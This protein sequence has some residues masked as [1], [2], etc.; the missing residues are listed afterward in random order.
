MNFWEKTKF[1]WWSINRLAIQ[2]SEFFQ[3]VFKQETLIYQPILTPT[4]APSITYQC[5]LPIFPPSTWF[6]M[7]FTW[8]FIKKRFKRWTWMCMKNF[9][10]LSTS[11]R[12]RLWCNPLDR[13]IL[14]LKIIKK[15]GLLVS[16]F[17]DYHPRLLGN[18]LWRMHDHG[19]VGEWARHMYVTLSLVMISL[20][21]W[22]KRRVNMCKWVHV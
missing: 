19:G 13:I 16:C 3:I 18:N 8:Y 11:K 10:V 5:S 20:L 22:D 1:V 7:G 12:W 15:G 14:S 9:D 21:R 6:P 2:C 4:Q 17:D